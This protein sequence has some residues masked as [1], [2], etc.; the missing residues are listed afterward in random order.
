MHCCGDNPCIKAESASL[1]LVV[2]IWS[3]SHW[4]SWVVFLSVGTTCEVHGDSDPLHF[5][6]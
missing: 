6:S 3:P 4:D 5:A 2:A 1:G